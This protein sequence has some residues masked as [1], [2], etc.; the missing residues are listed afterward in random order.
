MRNNRTVWLSILATVVVGLAFAAF[1]PWV[2]SAASNGV[3]L[4]GTVKSASGE[5]MAGV[6][7]STKADGQTITTS[8]FTDD[9]GEYYFPPLPSGKYRI[10]AQADTF[11]TGHG[12]VSL[13]ET[14]HQDFV[15]KPMRDFERQLTG[16]QILAA[17][18]DATPEDRR[19]KRIFRNNCTS[20]HQPNY[21]L[22]NRFDEQGW[23]A[24]MNLMKQIS[25]VG[26]F[27]GEDSGP[28]PHIQYYE[29]ELAAYLTR[30][31]GPGPSA[32][33][34]KLRPRPTGVPARTVFTEYD[35]PLDPANSHE[36]KYVTNDGSD[37]S[38]GTPSSTNGS[39]GIHDAQIDLNGNIWFTY[40]LPSL[41]ITYGRVDAKTGE[42]RFFKLPGKGGLAAASHGM[43]RDQKGII[44]ADIR[45]SATAQG[46]GGAISRIDPTSEKIEVFTTPPDMAGPASTVDV[47]GKGYIWAST[48]RG[49][50]RLDPETH[51]FKEFLSVTSVNSDGFGNGYG[52][53]A[54]RDGNAWWAEMSIDIIGR[55]DV[56]TGQ[57]S[58][59]RLAPVKEQMDLMSAKELKMNAM[60][61]SDFHTSVPWA[62]GPRRM[63]ADKTGDVIWVCD[64]WGGNLFQINSRTL[65]TNFVPLPSADDEP[66]HATVD[67]NHNV[68]VNMMDDDRIMEYDPK[69]SEWTAFPLPTLGAE[70]RYV[71]LLEHNGSMELVVPY[72]R[73]RKIALM[74]IRTKEELQALKEQAQKR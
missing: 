66:Y 57:S 67:S 23:T 68:W 69:K 70:S 28:D 64:T 26:P 30:M 62:Q 46:I 18:P 9:N 58:E 8:V 71:S 39:N 3:L 47:D 59:I 51:A 10:W 48:S 61:G 19:M 52:I 12:E 72:S 36:T 14:R 25:I 16:D 31:R 33:N 15:L 53:A 63:G 6:T 37:W 1:I 38:L 55:V 73:A 41:D 49:A 65:K 35:V 60:T 43:V 22:Q 21:I 20:C 32:M 29:K 17:L 45:G 54:D 56:E 34:F 24:I 44:W 40:N 50:V 42:V 74:T 4:A 11:E 13:T 2:V 27:L 5:K 7:V